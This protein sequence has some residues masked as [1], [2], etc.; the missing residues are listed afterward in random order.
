MPRMRTFRTWIRPTWRYITVRHVTAAGI[1]FAA[2]SFGIACLEYWHKGQEERL[3]RALSLIEKANTEPAAPQY[4]ALAATDAEEEAA[5]W[6]AVEARRALVVKFQDRFEGKPI[7]VNPLDRSLAQS[8]LDTSLKVKFD[9]EDRELYEKWD[10]ARRHLNELEIFAFAYV[11]DFADR[12][13][14]AAAACGP[15]VRSNAYFKELIDVLKEKFGYAQSWQI[16]PKAV[17]MMEH[18]W[19]TG[20][21]KIYP[22]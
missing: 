12:K 10:T 6:K 22:K 16:I 5:K 7:P 11:Y 15:M 8:L 18:D 2:G 17:T 4:H 20:C 14:L 3:Q 13:L 19:G 1:V 21:E 9:T